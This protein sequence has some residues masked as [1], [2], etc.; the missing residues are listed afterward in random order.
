MPFVGPA[1][2]RIERRSADAVVTL[3]AR[4]R[5]S[6]A[7]Y[8][9][10]SG[11][12]ASEFGLLALGQSGFVSRLNTV[13]SVTLDTADRVLG[14]MGETPIGPT[15]RRE[16]EAFLEVTGVD[17]TTFGTEAAGYAHFVKR[18][19]EGASPRLSTVDRVQRRMRTVATRVERAAIARILGDGGEARPIG[20]RNRAARARG[21]AGARRWNSDKESRRCDDLPASDRQFFL[22]TAQA[23]LILNIS[24][25][26]LDRFRTTGV[27]PAYCKMGGRVLYTQADLLA[28]AWKNRH[29][30]VEGD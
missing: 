11:M 18:L 2:S 9:S 20:S 16:V 24:P 28:W 22:S 3:D 12:G 4:F 21:R 6:V 26:T 8:I 1:G 7:D 17:E 23:A 19:R 27:G 10:L 14:F 15:F 30:T 13:Q 25:R 5:R 29:S